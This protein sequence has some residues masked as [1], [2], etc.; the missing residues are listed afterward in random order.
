MGSTHWLQME[1]WVL[2]TGENPAHGAL[3]GQAKSGATFE[4]FGLAEPSL[5][6]V[7]CVCVCVCKHVQHD[8]PCTP[9]PR[10]DVTRHCLWIGYMP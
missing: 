9:T 5:L 7:V 10:T 1:L 2:S 8:G 4:N 3:D 6:A